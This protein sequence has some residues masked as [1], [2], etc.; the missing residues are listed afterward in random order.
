MQKA[1]EIRL[2]TTLEQIALAKEEKVN[3]EIAAREVL[4][5]EQHKMEEVV[6]ESKKLML[7]VE[8]NSKVSP[9]VT[10]AFC[11]I[12]HYLLKIVNRFS[13]NVFFFFLVFSCKRSSWIVA[14]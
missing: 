1:L 10:K 14:K 7:E 11:Y 3:K 8:E 5:Y 13:Y 12:K 2:A 4:S 9:I 6:E